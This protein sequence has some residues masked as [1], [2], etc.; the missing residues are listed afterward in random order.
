MDKDQP[1]NNFLIKYFLFAVPTGGNPTDRL[2][3]YF[4]FTYSSR[5]DTSVK[6]SMPYHPPGYPGF[7]LLPATLKNP[8]P[9][10]SGLC[11]DFYALPETKI[12]ST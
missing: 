6:S 1:A 10:N 8:Y 12:S 7:F 2:I 3:Q 4:T 9:E 11:A 5:R